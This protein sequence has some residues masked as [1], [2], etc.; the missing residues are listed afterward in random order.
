MMKNAFMTERQKAEENRK[1]LSVAVVERKT[2]GLE[3]ER[4][5]GGGIRKF[6]GRK[7]PVAQA[8]AIP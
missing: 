8:P 2:M 6:F 7:V 4:E 3:K 1:K 5:R